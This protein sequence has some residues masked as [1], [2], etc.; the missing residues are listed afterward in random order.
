MKNW[1]NSIAWKVLPIL[2][3]C[4][5]LYVAI[6]SYKISSKSFVLSGKSFLIDRRPYLL[7]SPKRHKIEEVYVSSKAYSDKIELRIHFEMKNVGKTPARRLRIA[8]SALHF[9]TDDASATKMAKWK[10]ASYPM[11]ETELGPGD[12]QMLSMVYTLPVSSND[13]ERA[14]QSIEIQGRC[15]PISMT[16]SYTGDLEQEPYFTSLEACVYKDQARIFQ[17]QMK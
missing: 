5:A 8:H 16:L 4:I 1:S 11:P 3:S 6:A 14:V 15:V 12:D 10:I 9:L 7:L 13:A 2:V 17:T